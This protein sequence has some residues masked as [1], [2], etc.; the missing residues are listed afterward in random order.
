MDTGWTSGGHYGHYGRLAVT[1]VTTVTT[2]TAQ[3][4]NAGRHRKRPSL[5]FTM[6]TGSP[7]R[8]DKS[9]GASSLLLTFT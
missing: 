3:E 7:L 8:G 6:A 9:A 4:L 1:T 5:L 2:K